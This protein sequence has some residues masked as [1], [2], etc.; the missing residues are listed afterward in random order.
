MQGI[1]GIAAATCECGCEWLRKHPGMAM[2]P[3]VCAIARL[4]AVTYL[5]VTCRNCFE[6]IFTFS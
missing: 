6:L 4:R 1:S 2:A 5:S 3:A